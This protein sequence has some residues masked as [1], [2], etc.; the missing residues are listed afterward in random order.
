VKKVVNKGVNML[1]VNVEMK[2]KGSEMEKSVVFEVVVV[3][4]VVVVDDDVV[5]VKSLLMEM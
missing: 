4:V 3:E 1:F 5:I 2:I